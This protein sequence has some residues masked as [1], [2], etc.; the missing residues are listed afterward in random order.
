VVVSVPFLYLHFRQ[1]GGC[2]GFPAWC[3]NVAFNLVLLAL[4]SDFHRRTYKGA[5]KRA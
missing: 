2:S 5:K 1:P 3:G 4:F